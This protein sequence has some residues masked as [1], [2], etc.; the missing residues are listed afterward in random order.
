M[1]T[2]RDVTFEYPQSTFALNV[3]R[4]DVPAGEHFAITGPSGCGKTTLLQ[5]LAGILPASAGQVQV[6]GVELSAMSGTERR[7]FRITSVGQVFQNFE[8]LESLNLGDN[9]LLPYLINGALKLDAGARTRA[10]ELAMSVGLG[11]MLNRS[12]TMLS[13]GER[14]R[15]AIC[16]S[17]ITR[18]KL[19]LADEPTGNLDANSK[20]A[21]MNLLHE[22]A[23]AASA[24]LIVVTHDY[25]LLGDFD[26]HLDFAEIAAEA[27]VSTSE[28]SR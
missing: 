11:E 4:L 23:R 17:V 7:S 21:T 22:Q 5:I 10:A 6:A 3:P 1:I 16:R 24:T 20:L 12:V 8:L 14:Q 27:V 9:I 19:I 25:S 26:R 28:D 18:P 13:Q 15:A 2:V